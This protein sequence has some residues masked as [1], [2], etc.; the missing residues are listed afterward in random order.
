MASIHPLL[1]NTY[2]FPEQ[3]QVS[4]VELYLPEL[5]TLTLQKSQTHTDYSTLQDQIV[6]RDICF[7]VAQNYNIQTLVDHIQAIDHVVGVDI[8][9]IYQG[10]QLAVGIKSVTINLD[11]QGENMD[12]ASINIVLDQAITIGEKL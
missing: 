7:L 11:I 9:D 6:S 4:F 1:I 3:A 12:T 8:L 10:T 2:K 5:L